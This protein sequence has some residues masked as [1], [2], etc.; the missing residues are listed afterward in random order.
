MLRSRAVASALD[1]EESFPAGQGIHGGA[2]VR[3][4]PDTWRV[5]GQV[6]MKHGLSTAD[7]PKRSLRRSCK[8]REEIAV[9]KR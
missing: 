9:L 8:T 2:H 1:L 3:L 5:V 4:H 6:T 7:K